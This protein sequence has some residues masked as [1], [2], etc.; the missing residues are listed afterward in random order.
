MKAPPPG[1]YL[2]VDPRGHDRHG[3]ID[4]LE[5]VLGA[6]V[7]CVQLRD[8]ERIPDRSEA[9]ARRLLELCRLR[10]V[11]LLINDDPHWAHEL[12]ADGI[13][14]G[15][16]DG[17]IREARRLLGPDAWIGASAYA[18]L[19]HARN[20]FRE[21]ADY[22]AFGSFFP[23]PTKPHAP[24]ATLDLLREARRTLPG[25]ICAIGGIRADNA[26]S[27]RTAGADWVAVISAVWNAPDPLA[28]T[29]ALVASCAVRT[30][31]GAGGS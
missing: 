13:H 23:S 25:P 28:A 12:G 24:H 9:F 6:G 3:Q 11:P 16:H 14:L 1:L 19:N 4:L 17:T 15:Q 20:A 7:T 26:R 8:K 2:I 18:D 30:G 31:T 21:G 29:R 22:V 27:V 10:G 5:Q